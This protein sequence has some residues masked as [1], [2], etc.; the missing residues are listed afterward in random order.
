MPGRQV[1]SRAAAQCHPRWCPGSAPGLCPPLLLCPLEVPR[2]WLHARD[3]LCPSGSAGGSRYTCS[4][5]TA[6]PP[7][8]LGSQSP[9]R[10]IRAGQ[11]A[12]SVGILPRVRVKIRGGALVSK[13]TV[14]AEAGDQASTK[15]HPSP[16]RWERGPGSWGAAPPLSSALRPPVRRKTGP[17]EVAVRPVCSCH[18]QPHKLAPNHPTLAPRPCEE[19][20]PK[21]G[22]AWWTG[23]TRVVRRC[24]FLD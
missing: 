8:S 6:G 16:E 4:S 21:A 17:A 1:A 10:T 9:K 12:A 5:P 18:P 19:L 14:H 22:G 15:S 2:R 23:L 20:P 11:G 13:G 24:L 7:E 3:S